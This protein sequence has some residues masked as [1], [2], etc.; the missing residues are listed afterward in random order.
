MKL[1]P[2]C[3]FEGLHPSSSLNKNNS[4]ASDRHVRAQVRAKN[5]QTAKQLEELI[6]TRDFLKKKIQLLKR[7]GYLNLIFTW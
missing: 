1:A 7:L 6:S 2:F 5:I 3:P 4:E